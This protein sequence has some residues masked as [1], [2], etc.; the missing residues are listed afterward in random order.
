MQDKFLRFAVLG[1]IIF[2]T[3]FLLAD[4][5][6]FR[7]LP[8]F[9][10][11][12]LFGIASFLFAF[13]I[14]FLSM[15]FR[16]VPSE[17]MKF[18]LNFQRAVAITFILGGLG[19][20]GLFQL[21]KFGFE[22]DKLVHFTTAFVLSASFA[23]LISAR[24]NIEFKRAV[25]L[26]AVAVVAAGFV[27]ELAEFAMDAFLKTKTFGIY[28]MEIGK[29]TIVDILMNTLGTV[30]GVIILTRKRKNS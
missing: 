11:P 5:L 1:F 9:Y 17:T 2:G 18:P 15:I 8:D 24:C 25:M 28:G 4:F 22:Y 6:D 26:A 7:W 14:V 27:W 3:F 21:Y 20:L 12:G 29:D 30:S 10:A 16:P 19:S 23:G 13:G